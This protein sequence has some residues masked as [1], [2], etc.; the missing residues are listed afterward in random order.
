MLGSLSVLLVLL[1]TSV[2]ADLPANEYTYSF[3][4]DALLRA[5]EIFEHKKDKLNW[6]SSQCYLLFCN[7]C[8]VI[9]YYC[10]MH[11]GRWHIDT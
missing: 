8:R 4:R 10:L 11:K 5:E 3:N 2:R 6:V 9:V 7:F 1:S